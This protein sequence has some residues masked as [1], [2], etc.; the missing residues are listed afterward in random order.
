[1]I[2]KLVKI[3]KQIKEISENYEVNTIGYGNSHRIT[4]FT[5][6]TEKATLEFNEDTDEQCNNI[7]ERAAREVLGIDDIGYREDCM[8]NDIKARIATMQIADYDSVVS[9]LESNI[10]IKDYF[11]TL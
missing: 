1:M 3:N 9:L 10:N 6:N 2:L 5:D 7:A 4:T 8:Y 11:V